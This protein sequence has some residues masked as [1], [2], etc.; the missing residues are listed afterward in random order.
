MNHGI[1]DPNVKGEGD[2]RADNKWQHDTL[3]LKKS[4]DVL[5]EPVSK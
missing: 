1:G 3:R 5:Q 2:Q 4:Q